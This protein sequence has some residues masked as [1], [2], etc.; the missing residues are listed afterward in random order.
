MNEI[1]CVRRGVTTFTSCK[2]ARCY[3]DYLRMAKR[4]RTG[5]FHRVPAADAL[6]V[7]DGL[8]ERRWSNLALASATGLNPSTCSNILNKRKQGRDIRLGAVVSKAIV[9]H[10]S[11]TAGSISSLVPMRKVRA[12]ARIGYTIQNMTDH[13][14]LHGTTIASIREGRTATVRVR[15]AAVIDQMYVDLA[16]KPGPS[17]VARQCATEHGWGGP[18]HWENI[19]DPNERPRAGGEWSEGAEDFDETAI[20]RRMHGDRVHL[21]KAEQI[22]LVHRCLKAKWSHDQIERITGLNAVRVLGRE[23]ASQPVEKA[24]DNSEAA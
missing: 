2:C 1:Q 12:L 8:I 16:M 13:S 15:L 11:P 7:L 3:P 21:T 19:D 5:R 22:E 23:T 24:V 20:Y 9:E 17:P 6:K 18:L 10:G 14:G 4:L